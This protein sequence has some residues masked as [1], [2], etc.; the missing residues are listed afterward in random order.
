MIYISELVV[1]ASGQYL[2]FVVSSGLFLHPDPSRIG[3]SEVGNTGLNI[4]MNEPYG[5]LRLVNSKGIDSLAGFSKISAPN[6]VVVSQQPTKQL[7]DQA[8]NLLYKIIL[9]MLFFYILVFYLI[10]RFSYVIAQ[11][12]SDLADSASQL[13]QPDAEKNIRK[14][15]PWYFE[16]AQFRKALLSSANHFEQRVEEL[17]VIVKTDPL[18]GFYNRRGMQMY[19][20]SFEKQHTPVSI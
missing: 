4:L 16:V 19:L 8:S 7:L 1:D 9:G 2:G 5:N 6:W 18:T 14:I 17:N 11:P 3:D 15:R 12:L 10:W 13:N 20:E